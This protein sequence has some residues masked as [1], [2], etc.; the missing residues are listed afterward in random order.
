M[1]L[2]FAS[3]KHFYVLTGIRTQDFQFGKEPQSDE[4]NHPAKE[5]P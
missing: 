3:L 1:Y 2:L 5:T 4:L